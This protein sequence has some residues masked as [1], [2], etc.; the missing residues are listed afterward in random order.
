V[1]VTRLEEGNGMGTTDPRIDEYIER[2]EEFA[3]P[4]LRHL[5]ALVH[6]G[7]PEVEETIRW[8]F[9][10]FAYH[11]LLCSMASFRRHCAF[12]FWKESLVL[13][14]A[15][16]SSREAMGQFGRIASLQDLP[17]D[18]VLLGY[19]GRAAELNREGVRVQRGAA[20]AA[21]AERE[22]DE[23]FRTA[24]AANPAAAANFEAFSPSA[25]REYLEW[26][27]DARREDTRARRVTTAVEWI[28]EGKPRNWKYIRDR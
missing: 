24:L 13:E 1:D 25:R 6:R 17:D 11:G 21:R 15:T 3:R 10:H 16:E 4:I 8:G 5:R 12:G 14:G 19:L 26:V 7:C 2:S 27:A 22:T 18:E 23:G 20:A 28:A 9:P